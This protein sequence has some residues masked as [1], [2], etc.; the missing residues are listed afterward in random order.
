M[1]SHGFFLIYLAN[2]SCRLLWKNRNGPQSKGKAWKI[3]WNYKKP[4]LFSCI[5]WYF[6]S[7]EQKPMFISSYKLQKI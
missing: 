1:I 6:T 5:Y 3:K 2:L 4:W 7:F